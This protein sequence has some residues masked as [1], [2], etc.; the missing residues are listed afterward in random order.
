MERALLYGSWL[1]VGMYMQNVMTVARAFGLE[2]C[3]QQAWC[4]YGNVLR[5]ELGIDE[6]CIL[7][8]GMSLGYEDKAAKENA[9][10]TERAAVDAFATFH[11]A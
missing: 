1:D 6:K 2:T 8:S 3:P 9:L 11:A 4:H 7:I 10:T 5:R